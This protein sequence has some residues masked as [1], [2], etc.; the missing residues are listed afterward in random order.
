MFDCDDYLTSDSDESLPPS[1][2]YD[3][4]QSGDGYHVVPPPYTE[5]FMPPKRN[6]VFHNAPNDVETV[7]TTFNVDLG[8]T[9]PNKDLSPTPKP[10]ESIIEDWVSDSKDDSEAKIPQNVP[11]F[12]QPNEQVKHPR[13]SVKP[14]ETSIPAANPKI[15]ISKPS[16]T[17]NSRN[18]KACFVCKSLTHLIKDCDFYEKKM[19]QTTARNHAQRGNHKQPV[20]TAVPK[21]TVTRPRQAK[22]V[23]TK[24]NSPPRRHI[25]RSP[26]PKAINFPPKVTAVT[27]PMVNA[28]KGVIDSGCSRHMKGNMSYLSN[29]EELNGGYVAFGD[30]PKG[31]K[32]SG[33]ATKDETSPILKTFIIGIE[34]QLSLKV[35]IIKSDNGT[36]FK[37]NDLNQLCGMKGIK[38][39]FSV[40]RTPQKNGIAERK[41]RTLIKA[42]KTM[43]V[44][45]LLPIP[46]WAEVVNTTCYVQNKVLVTKPQN[47]T[48]YELL[49]G[50]T[51]SIGFIRPFGCLVT[52]LNTLDS[53]GKFDGKVDEGFLV[54]Y[55]VSS[56][57]FRV[58]NNRTQIVQETLHINFLENKPNVVG[59][60]P[61][62][63]FD[64]DTLTKTINY[65]PVTA[66]NQSNPSA[67]VQE[68][69][70]AEKAKEDI[71]QQY[72]LFPVWSS[73]STN[74]H[75]TDG[76]DAF[77]KKEPE[78]QRRKPESEVNVSP[79]SSAQSK[80]HDDKTKREAKGKSHVESLTGYRNLS[81]EFKDF[82]DNNI[83]EVNAVDSPVPAVRQISTNSTN[84]FSAVGP[85]NAV[86]S[87]TRGKSSYVDSS[88]LP[89]DP[90]MPE[91]ED[92]TYSDDK[93]D[94]GAEADFTNLEIS[95]TVS[96]IPTTRVHKDHHVTQIIGDLSSATQTRSMTRVAKD[97]GG[98][99]QINNDDYHTCMF[100]CFL[101]Q[102]EP[103]RVH[104]AFKV[105]SWI[106]AMQEELLQFKIQKVWVLVNLPYGKRAI[107]LCKAFE[108]LMKDKFQMS[109]MGE[110]T[111]FLGLQV[112]QKKDGIFISQDK[113]V[114][115]VLR[116]FGLIDGKSASTPIDTKKP[117]L[118]DLDGEDV[119]LSSMEA[120]KRMLHVTNILSAG[121]LTTPQM[122]L[123]SPCLTHI[124]NWLVQIKRS[125]SSISVKT[126]NDVP[127]L[128]ALVDKKKVIISE[129]TIRD[130]LHLD[131][132]E[133]RKFNFS[134]YIFDSLVRTVDSPTK[135]YMYP[136]FL[137]LMIKKQVGDLSLYT[138]KYSSPALTRKVFA[139]M[140]R[141]GKGCFGVETPLFEGLIVAQQVGEGA[142]EVNVKDVSTAGVAAEGAAS[143][144]DDEVS[145]A[146]NEPSIPLP[147]LPT[148]PQS[149]DLPST[150]QR[151]KKLERRNET[152]KLRILKKV[153]TT[154]R[155]ETSDDT[156]MD[157]VSKK[158][159]IIADMDANKDMSLK[160]VAAVAKDVQDAKIK[161]SSDV[162]GRKA[163]SQEQIYQIDLEHA[164]KVLSMQDVDIEP[165]ELQEVV[166]VVTTAKL[167]T[168]VVTTASTTIT[169]TAPQLTTAA[170]LTLTT[171]PSAAKMRK[172]AKQ[173]YRLDE[174][175]DHVQR[176]EKEDNAVKR[177][178][179]SNVAFLQKTKDQMEE[180]DSRALKR[181][182][183]SQEDK[184]TPLARKVLVV[185]YE[186]YTENNKPYYK[187]IRADGSPQLFLS[188]LSLL[189]NFDREDLEV[190]WELV[191]ESSSIE[192]S[193]NS[194]W[195][196]KGQNLEVVRVM[197]SAHY[198]I[199]FY[200]DDLASRDK[201]STFKVHSGSTDQQV[202]GPTRCDPVDTPMVEKSKL[203]EDKEGKV[204]DPSHYRGMI[205]TL[206]YLTTS[207]PDL[208]FSI[209]MCTRYQ[210]S[211]NA[212]TAF[213]DADHAGCQDTCRSTSG[214]IQLLGD[215]LVSWS[216]KHIDIRFHF[217]K[218]HVK[219]DLIE[220]YF[221][222][223]E[224]QLADIFTKALGRERIEFLINK[225]G[226]R[227]LTPETLKQFADEFDE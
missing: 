199:Y 215:R 117:L 141:V 31:G 218:E 60:G 142:A 57:A 72:V 53:L 35:K 46:F 201:I 94:V 49:H 164:D 118:K 47:E 193:K 191:K 197:W 222:N 36:E 34:N 64:I 91:L 171:A 39:E 219:N 188:F 139:N 133:G 170:A 159:R 214:S 5:T 155:I 8:P 98:L 111:F 173:E 29:F 9:K 52:I 38:R 115:E 75:N 100:A 88:Q 40:P 92:I 105:P 135:V 82:S 213:A 20:T 190:L 22:I 51:P 83:N 96:P 32:I 70:D 137:Q 116:K 71:V 6:L 129:A 203:D 128:Q 220:L 227:S 216:S 150:S 134:K 37:N 54:G 192:E 121:S 43:L 90:N 194:S 10:L 169:A 4:Y 147:T 14:V 44:D 211:S 50:R 163:E 73:G 107:D 41:N 136:R 186:I 120:L 93:D 131:D 149:Q 156:I 177:K 221:V 84:T 112:K 132:A 182:S 189:K 165:A 63:L 226:M 148:Q 174:V 61:T 76:D 80:K 62:W 152:S 160:D 23:V 198:N 56:K 109:S 119:A 74:P 161:E 206:L 143:A 114:P 77:D 95:T 158:G 27:A 89:D 187:I 87:P 140:R 103:K 217:I 123:T 19:A 151:V 1:F 59:S 33:K 17:G 225:L 125:L 154:H 209:C 223:T 101:L 58:F 178:F 45:S 55:S 11:S 102:K 86:V 30:N 108:K 184:A 99:S 42:A 67:G 153:G 162:Q 146:V 181:L 212:L 2:I 138:T 104:Q 204:V 26:S 66:G 130:A 24:P 208:Q 48:L 110:L 78:F 144:A 15:A 25:N 12:V 16:S 122:V 3:R 124:K 195:F 200:T 106:K 145:A 7:H 202:K 85:S 127:R 65:Q 126:V 21:P 175:I 68:Q 207:R 28:A 185:D 113:Y 69:F 205:G 176:K 224:Y 210:D 79:S 157:D 180:E 18:R 179:N 81:A 167:I 168:E 172:G 13:P 183:E 97:Q 166:E 196:I